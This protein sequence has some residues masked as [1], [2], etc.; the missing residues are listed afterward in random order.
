MDL[1][2]TKVLVVNKE[3]TKEFLELLAKQKEINKQ[4]REK[5]LKGGK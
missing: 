5:F 3:R 4:N 1:N 2:K